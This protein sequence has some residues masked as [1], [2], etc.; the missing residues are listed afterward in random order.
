MSC[1]IY[2]NFRYYLLAYLFFITISSILLLKE[3]YLLETNN[4]MAEWFINYQGGFGRRGFFGEIFLFI[5]DVTGI[6][7]KKV[8]LIFLIFLIFFYHSLLFFYL[9]NIKFNFNIIIIIF[10]PLFFINSVTFFFFINLIVS[11]AATKPILSVHAVLL[12]K[13]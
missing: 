8:I 4:S 5:S 10:S 12:I 13:V 2:K 1:K 6:Y 11:N 9:K 7:L 3:S